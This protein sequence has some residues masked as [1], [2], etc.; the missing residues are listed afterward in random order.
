MYLTP[1]VA[2]RFEIMHEFKDVRLCPFGNEDVGT[3]FAN[4]HFT[5]LF[6]NFRVVGFSQT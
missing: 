2:W 5:L 1:N 4:G 6:G 3:T